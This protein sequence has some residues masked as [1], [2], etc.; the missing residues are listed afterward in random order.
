MKRR[1][2]GFW[3]IHSDFHAEPH[4]GVMGRGLREEDI[5]EICRLLKPDFWQ[6]D[7]KGHP[8]W[9]SYPTELDNALPEYA[10]DT[11]AVWRKATEAEDVALVAHYSG[12]RDERYCP[13]H[14]EDAV[15]YADGTRS[16]AATRPNGNYADNL[17]IPQ[18]SEMIEK[19]HVD[20]VWV[21]GEC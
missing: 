13:R 5:R 14:P 21:D 3:G 20:G 9:A 18:L 8:G 17:L 7:T 11:L 1:N 16:L 12:V 2:E 4:F 6:I 10:C 15:M 19:Y